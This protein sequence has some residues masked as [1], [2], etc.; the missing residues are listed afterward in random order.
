VDSGPSTIIASVN[1]SLSIDGLSTI[2]KTVEIWVP[3]KVVP[4]CL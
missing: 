2:G 4:M 3:W 1:V